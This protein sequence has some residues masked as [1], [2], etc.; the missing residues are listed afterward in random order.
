M[1]ARLRSVFVDAPLLAVITVIGVMLPYLSK[2]LGG[3]TV[4]LL[5]VSLALA[6]LT[7]VFPERSI[8][9]VVITVMFFSLVRRIFPSPT[10]ASDIAAIFPFIVSA[11]LAWRGLRHSSPPSVVFFLGWSAATIILSLGSP[12]VG[13][14]G[15]TNLAVPMTVGLAAGRTPDGMAMLRRTFA[16]ASGVV[17]TYGIMQYSSPFSWDVR[18]LR[19]AH[20]LSAGRVGTAQF[21]PFATLPAPGTLAIVAA[22]AVLLVVLPGSPVAGLTRAWVGSACGLVLLLTQVRSVWIATAAALVVAALSNRRRAGRTIAAVGMLGF[23]LVLLVPGKTTLV[24][25]VRTLSSPSGDTSYASR[26]DLL[27]SGAALATPLGRG[28]GQYSAGNRVAG[29]Q[30]LD[31]GYIVVLGETGVIGFGLLIWV[32]GSAVRGAGAHDYPFLTL[33]L[34]VNAAGFAIGGVGAIMLWATSGL[35][36]SIPLQPATPPAA[37]ASIPNE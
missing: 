31:N 29:G 30:S 8:P 22:V 7:V 10:P 18:W 2:A 24:E 9:I 1:T 12:L 37:R 11:P 36:S 35:Q 32:L 20:F 26:A 23:V 34:I 17:A 6:G 14:A 27:R 28:I 19:D 16:L 13:V 21:R 33:L 25:R 3:R 5:A 4:A 15:I